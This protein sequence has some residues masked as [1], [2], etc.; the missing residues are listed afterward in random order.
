MD[1]LNRPLTNLQEVLY[2]LIYK[3]YISYENFAYMQGF[4]MRISELRRSLN[5]ISTPKVKYN[6]YGNS[7]V[8]S[9]HRLQ[10]SEIEKAVIL[11]NKLQEKSKKKNK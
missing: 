8:M 1:H 4:R 9:L 3:D 7:Y 6:K 11:Y 5:I 2:E 10:K